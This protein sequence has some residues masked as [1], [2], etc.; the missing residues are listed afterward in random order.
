MPE[1]RIDVYLDFANRSQTRPAYHPIFLGGINV[2]SGNKPPWSLPAKAS[3]LALDT[4]R[5]LRRVGLGHLRT[6]D[7]LMSF[8]MTVQPLRAIHYVKAHHPPAVFLAAFHFLIDRAWTPP[9]RRIADPEVLREVLGEATE[10]VKGGRKLF[11][12]EQVEAI[13][14]GRAAFKDSVKQETDVALSKGAFGAPWIW[15]TN[16]KGEEEPFFGSDRFNH[17]YAFLDIPFQDVTVLSPNK[18]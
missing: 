10:S 17:I 14:E 2:A 9:N 13:M 8:G 12:T 1:A 11:T 3:Y 15:V 18:L 6:P 16:A 5:A 4:P 7:D